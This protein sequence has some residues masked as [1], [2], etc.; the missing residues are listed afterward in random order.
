ML[1]THAF[2]KTLTGAGMPEAQAEAVTSLVRQARE[3][4]LAELATKADLRDLAT[5]ADLRDFATKADLRDF[6]TKA[7]LAEARAEIGSVR[8]E[9]GSV[10][11]EIGEAEARLRVVIAETKS[12]LLKWMVGMVGGAVVINAMTVVG[13]M[14]A[15]L[16]LT[17]H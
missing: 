14:V 4:R 15:L 9:V 2:V 17:A 7:D 3:D 5:K 8:T 1:D 11:T 16:K 13:A 10:R 12:E 6:A